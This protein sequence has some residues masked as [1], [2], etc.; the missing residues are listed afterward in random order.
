ML[1]GPTI[2]TG[3]EETVLQRVKK[4]NF[5][6]ND[7]YNNGKTKQEGTLSYDLNAYDYYKTGKWTYYNEPT[8]EATKEET[9]NDGKVA[10]TKEL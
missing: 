5:T 2:E 6:Q 3:Q 8:G 1:N 9:Y 7:F 10:K 4:L